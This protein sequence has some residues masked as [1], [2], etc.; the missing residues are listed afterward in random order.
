[1]RLGDE[2]AYARLPEHTESVRVTLV[3]ESGKSPYF[4]NLTLYLDNMKTIETSTPEWNVSGKLQL[5]QVGVTKAQYW[6]WVVI[7]AAVPILM[8]VTKKQIDRAKKIK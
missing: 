6:S 8:Y 3:F 1:Y 2:K 4:R 5:V 7:I